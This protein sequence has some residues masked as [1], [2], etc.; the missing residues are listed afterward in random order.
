MESTRRTA[1]IT[2]PSD[3]QILIT[4]EF[5][6]PKH[7]VYR[8]WTTP[9]LVKQWWGGR[10]GTVESVEIDL[11]VGGRWRYVMSANGGFQVA[12]HG[13]Y[14]ELVPTER[15]VNTEV[16]ETPDADPADEEHAP[17]ITTTFSEVSGRTVLALLTDAGS[18]Q[19]RDVILNSG[20][21][22]GVQEGFELL[23]QIAADLR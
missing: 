17:I 12:F 11:R 21:E 18:R 13:T 15:I 1:T 16:F 19:L 6:A 5:D 9:A 4:R 14:R 8:A 23:E 2:L 10:R 20:M 3:E 7:L 22:E